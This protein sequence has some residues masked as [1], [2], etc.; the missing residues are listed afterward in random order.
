VATIV[1]VSFG[2]RVYVAEESCYALGSDTSLK[3]V[4]SRGDKRDDVPGLQD[5]VEAGVLI[6]ASRRM[7]EVLDS[8][9]PPKIEDEQATTSAVDEQRAERA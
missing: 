7:S 4:E 2:A 1:D 6:P 8:H 3:G 9:P 5:L